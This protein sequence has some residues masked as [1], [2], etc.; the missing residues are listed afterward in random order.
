MGLQVRVAGNGNVALAEAAHP[1]PGRHAGGHRPAGHERLRGG[2]GDP[3]RSRPRRHHARRP[4]RLRP[5]GRPPPGA[6]RRLR[7][8]PGEAG[9]R[10]PH[11]TPDSRALDRERRA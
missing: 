6:P 2:E 3:Q 8:P 11:P 1:P 4:H 10:R 9:R 7:P 5:G